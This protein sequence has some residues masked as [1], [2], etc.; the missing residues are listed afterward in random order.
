MAV[1]SEIYFARV[2]SVDFIGF[3]TLTPNLLAFFLLWYYLSRI[4]AYINSDHITSVQP[5]KL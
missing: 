2:F 4:V 1:D 3:Y 5:H